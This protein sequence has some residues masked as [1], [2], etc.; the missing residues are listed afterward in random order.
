MPNDNHLGRDLNRYATSG[1]EESPAVAPQSNDMSPTEKLRAM[2]SS[3]TYNE[4]DS[5]DDYGEDF[6]RFDAL[7]GVVTAD[8]RHQLERQ[9]QLPASETSG[10]AGRGASVRQKDPRT[11]RAAAGRHHG[12]SA[13]MVHTLGPL[14]LA[15]ER[16]TH[17]HARHQGCHRCVGGCPVNA[18]QPGA[19]LPQIDLQTCVRCG[20]CVGACPSGAL[21]WREMTGRQ[22][23]TQLKAALL[24]WMNA[25]Q[26]PVVVFHDQPDEDTVM[27]AGEQAE[28]LWVRVSPLGI[29]DMASILSALAWGAAGVRVLTDPVDHPED[30]PLAQAMAW[31]TT[32]I[33]ALGWPVE[34]IG[35][36]ASHSDSGRE[37]WP[38]T[39]HLA[40]PAADYTPD[41]P[42]PVVV[43]LAVDHLCRH[44]GMTHRV[45][46]RLA[47]DAPW[48]AVH[49]DGDRC[50]LCMACAGACRTRALFAYD[51]Q[52]PGLHFDKR[53][54]VQCGLCAGTCPEQAISLVPGLDL[55]PAA[56]VGAA[57]L[58]QAEPARCPGCGRVF[59]SQ[60]MID[61]VRRKLQGHWMYRDEDA[62]QRLGMCQQ[63]R[64]QALLSTSEPTR[65]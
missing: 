21:V 8:M 41:H 4:S 47:E 6:R 65:T 5:L 14:T 20:V 15:A 53:L 58:H 46:V 19:M 32:L 7:G 26:P 31:S 11:R 64:L 55:D 13:V 61:T 51:G 62:E 35:W 40:V 38:K 60:Q 3:G 37:G 43:R 18:I 44:S 10:D 1:S 30:T 25:G 42:K 12:R 56:T 39:V 33:Q 24:S 34:A 54:C 49:V 23:L 16:C 63:C 28:A 59:A 2:L 52:P 48:G 9:D 36:L 17:A 27:G 22:V 50:T 45:G 57:V 29:L